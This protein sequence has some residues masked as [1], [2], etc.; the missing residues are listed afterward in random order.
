MGGGEGGRG[1]EGGVAIPRLFDAHS[2]SGRLECARIPGLNYGV[3]LHNCWFV[4]GRRNA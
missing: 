2:S 4:V 3:E 1:E